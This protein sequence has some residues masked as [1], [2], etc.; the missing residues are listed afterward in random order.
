MNY[1]L[2]I[3]LPR[4]CQTRLDVVTHGIIEMLVA[5]GVLPEKH[6][7][8]E[9]DTRRANENTIEIEVIEIE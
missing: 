2:N 8:R 7:L 5:L 4:A 1:R 3:K 9:L 6:A